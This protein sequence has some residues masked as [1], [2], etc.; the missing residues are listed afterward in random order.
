VDYFEHEHLVH[1]THSNDTPSSNFAT[2]ADANSDEQEDDGGE[3]PTATTPLSNGSINMSG[4]NYN[5]SDPAFIKDTTL[6]LQDM[7]DDNAYSILLGHAE[8]A[9]KDKQWKHDLVVAAKNDVD[10][11]HKDAF[12][13][14]RSTRAQDR[15]QRNAMI[16][17]SSVSFHKAMDFNPGVL[18]GD[19]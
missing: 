7:S 17:V 5:R 4:F 12:S 15:A 6:G 8:A 10:N 18:A 14:N 13:N 9:G 11:L 3:E 1:H 19:R 2:G 16:W